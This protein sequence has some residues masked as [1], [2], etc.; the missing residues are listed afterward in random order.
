MVLLDFDFRL[1]AI[2]DGVYPSF[3]AALSTFLRVA[4]EM[5]WNLLLFSTKETVAVLTPA[6]LATSL[7]VGFFKLITDFILPHIKA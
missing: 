1:L 6:S 4:S 5:D 7:I 3:F 2:S